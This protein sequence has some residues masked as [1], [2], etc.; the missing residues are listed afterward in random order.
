MGSPIA[1]MVLVTVWA[2][3]RHL[4]PRPWMSVD[5]H[6]QI[7]D[8]VVLRLTR[9]PQAVELELS[10]GRHLLAVVPSASPAADIDRRVNQSGLFRPE[11][12]R[13][14]EIDADL[15]SV[16]ACYRPFPLQ[17]WMTRGWLSIQTERT[18]DGC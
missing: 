10:E 4:L 9:Q 12:G 11:V 6:L 1:N 8:D 2:R 3:A 14:L 13:W 18:M 17:A 15:N 7:D 5:P 16:R